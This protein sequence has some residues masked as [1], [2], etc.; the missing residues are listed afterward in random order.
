MGPSHPSPET[1]TQD[2]CSL[3]SVDLLVL[4][5]QEQG[6]AINF[7][8]SRPDGVSGFAPPCG[9]TNVTALWDKSTQTVW[10]CSHETLFV[11]DRYKHKNTAVLATYKAHGRP[12]LTCRQ[13]LV[14]F[15]RKPCCSYPTTSS[16]K[17]APLVIAPPLPLSCRDPGTLRDCWW[18]RFPTQA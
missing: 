15:N 2:H 5:L 18:A 3:R 4:T 9:E 11:E 1:L 8:C 13:C 12:H 6:R 16:S 10:L 7:L 17:A 14:T